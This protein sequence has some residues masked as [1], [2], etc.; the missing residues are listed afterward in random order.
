[1]QAQNG[2]LS[3]PAITQSGSPTPGRKARKQALGP[4]L[5]SHFSA[6]SSCGLRW[7]SDS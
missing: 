2:I 7:A 4:N 3:Q 6:R 1:M 5:S